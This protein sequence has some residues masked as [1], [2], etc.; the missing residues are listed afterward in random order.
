MESYLIEM[1]GVSLAI[2]IFVELAIVLL[3]EKKQAKSLK[4][5]EGCEQYIGYR[6]S[7]HSRQMENRN[8]DRNVMSLIF[9]QHC[10]KGV[11]LVVLINVLTNPPAV[12]LCW[13][14]GLYMP[15]IPN[16]AVQLMVE[17]AVV[18]VEACIYRSFAQ[19]PQWKI[20]RPVRLA[21][22]ANVCSWLL[23]AIFTF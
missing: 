10:G 7:G 9:G 15:K 18:L 21:V 2:T 17:T 8:N 12:L 5:N 4:L 22:T 1:F 3:L 16:I 6:Q 23:G 11:L 14:G 20:A 19:R 13:L